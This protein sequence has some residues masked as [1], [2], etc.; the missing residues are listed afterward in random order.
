MVGCLPLAAALALAM[1]QLTPIQAP[2]RGA[3]LLLDSGFE[4]ATNWA[5]VGDGFALDAEVS[6]SGARSL[7]LLGRGR[8]S[9]AGARQVIT[10]DPPIRHPIRVSGASRAEGAV[11]GQ[12]Y[13]V[14]LDII[15]E[16]GTPLWGEKV[17]FAPGDHEW[18]AAERIVDV[19]KPIRAIE[20]HVLFRESTGT[21]WFDDIVVELAPLDL[22]EQTL[23]QDLFGRGLGFRAKTTL[24]GSWT[25]TIEAAG[26]ILAGFGP[27][28]T[29]VRLLWPG[30]DAGADTLRL[31]V[32]DDLLGET[33]EWTL[34]VEPSQGEATS[35][36]A[37][38]EDS[39]RRVRPNELPPERRRDL[40]AEVSLAGHEYESFQVLLL[41][42]PGSPLHDV[43]VSLSD[44]NGP[45]GARIASSNLT[46]NLVGYVWIENPGR[47]PSVRDEGPGWVPDALLPI[48]GFDVPEGFAQSLWV[49]VYAPAGTP[50][51][52]YSGALTIDAPG[53]PPIEVDISARVWGFSLPVTGHLKTAFALM[54]GFL[55]RVYG[56]PLD[57][58]IRR[59]Y[60]EMALRH[61][62]NPDD[63]SRTDLP[64]IDDLLHYRDLGMN[65]FNVLNMVEERGDRPWVCWSPLE[66]YTPEFKAQIASRLDPYAAQLEAAGLTDLA[67]IYTFDE[68]GD[69]F[70]EC[71][72][73]YFG[74]V[75]ERYPG[76]RTFTTARVPQDP[77]VL[78]VLNIDWI[79][80]L[81]PA[82]DRD[83]ADQCRAAGHEVWAY[84]C[85][86]PGQPYAN[87]LI[88]H[89][90][91]EARLLWWQAY[92]E[93]MDGILYWGLNIWDLA[94]NDRPIDPAAGQF[95]EW[96]VSNTGEYDWLHGDGRLI[97]AGVDGPIGSIRLANIR[98]G[99][100]D[101]E[102][103]WMLGASDSDWLAVSRSMTDFTREPADLRAAR[104]AIAGRLE[105]RSLRS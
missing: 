3:N 55:E 22:R 78:E 75:K 104:E 18:Q 103:L 15:F 88:D 27:E 102:C 13:N 46:C 72:A 94:H 67:Y 54:D 86:G 85:L 43:T 17:E 47:H 36:L 93:R 1:L 95:L 7:R 10:F 89:P 58:A 29:P 14:Y 12:D 28:P 41:S 57:P 2:A 59:A 35:V 53:V 73:E 66:V 69:E 92:A 8:G 91:I 49:T 82:Y 105:G 42:A 37:W 65:A 77:Q 84:V 30:A 74:M 23:R 101:Y 68:R 11:V 81:T 76:I 62:L 52:D 60:G 16:D 25:A 45:D 6:H 87:W 20:V 50:A 71:M 56:K 100:E 79:C 51:G 61:R 38:V 63:I 64:A 26:E 96:S 40:R 9:A 80:P 19:E 34:P 31:S 97:Y 39:M 5:P 4:K 70:R 98:D 44:L 24:P 21:V 48:R 99:L 33:R 83:A 32:T 90:L